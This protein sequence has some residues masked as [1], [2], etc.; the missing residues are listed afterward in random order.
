[1]LWVI[2]APMLAGAEPVQAKIT[3]IILTRSGLS[4][5][6][7]EFPVR[8]GT[9]QYVLK[10]VPLALDGTYWFEGL[11]GCQVL[12]TRTRLQFKDEAAKVKLVA[13]GDILANNLGKSVCLKLP[14]YSP[15]TKLP[16][17]TV[18]GIVRYVSPPN[19]GL[20][21]IELAAK[22]F[23]SV[24]VADILEV[25]GKGLNLV[26]SILE[27]KPNLSLIVEVASQRI[28]RV[29]IR[30]IEPGLAWTPTYRI[31]LEDETN[32]TVLAKYQVGSSSITLK[33]A[34]LTLIASEISL[35]KARVADMSS[36]AGTL[37]SF[38]S[39]GGMPSRRLIDRIVDPY[40]LWSMPSRSQRQMYAGFQYYG[41]GF[42]GGGFGGGGE[43]EYPAS[44]AYDES[45]R[46]Q[47]GGDQKAEVRRLDDLYTIPAGRLTL[48]PGDRV[49]KELFRAK[50]GYQNYYRWES[51]ASRTSS[52]S[53][54]NERMS[55]SVHR[56]LR[57]ETK[58]R[59]PLPAGLC[60]VTKAGIPMAQVNLPFTPPQMPV[61]LDL[62]EVTDIVADYSEMVVSRDRVSEP[63][64][65][66]TYS[67][68]KQTMEVSLAMANPRNQPIDVEIRFNFWGQPEG[69]T[70]GKV[71]AW[72]SAGSQNPGQSVIWRK[73]LEP[74]QRDS[75][76][77]R[78]WMRTY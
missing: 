44:A 78:Y 66:T 68:I 64:G 37:D 65:A 1:M 75:F 76:K 49:A 48:A 59:T 18:T 13:F 4:E 11:D 74:G 77:F 73:H 47:Q 17:E 27:R 46:Y 25:D 45:Y 24:K 16:P 40:I 32:A 29:A 5:I 60:V 69:A 2:L 39:R 70:D 35:P 19:I 22:S 67:F 61:D 38:L 6:T 15:L 50:V 57:L 28:G 42:G 36:G 62:G 3:S 14:R 54:S 72:Y 21:T 12:E 23:R 8:P 55:S 26:A 53:S 33:D 51:G 7:R 58:E 9:R 30:S 52:S 56:I 41:G 63:V 71:I 31:A 20:A 34:D 43:A 10:E